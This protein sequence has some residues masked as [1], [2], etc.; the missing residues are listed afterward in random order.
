MYRTTGLGRVR[1]R[2]SRSFFLQKLM[3]LYLGTEILLAPGL[4]LPVVCFPLQRTHVLS[5]SVLSA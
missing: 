5:V 2:R 1:V 3:T 4:L